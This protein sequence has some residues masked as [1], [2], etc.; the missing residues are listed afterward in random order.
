[1]SEVRSCLGPRCQPARRD[2]KR[3]TE[4]QRSER[5]ETRLMQWTGGGRCT[6][7]LQR[8]QMEISDERYAVLNLLLLCLLWLLLWLLCLVVCRSSMRAVPDVAVVWFT[9]RKRQKE[10]GKAREGKGQKTIKDPRKMERDMRDKRHNKTRLE[11]TRRDVSLTRTEEATYMQV[12]GTRARRR[13]TKA[14]SKQTGQGR[15]D[16]GLM[17]YEVETVYR[18][19]SALLPLDQYATS[20]TRKYGICQAMFF[21]FEHPVEPV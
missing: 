11:S 17:S 21:A 12:A 6:A 1:M 20:T 16:Q 19:H 7:A 18:Y 9:K 15:V 4:S 8:R 3:R 14:K 5:G 2:T 13:Q 10:T